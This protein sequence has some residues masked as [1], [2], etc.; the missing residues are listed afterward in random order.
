MIADI[1]G[2]N[3]HGWNSILLRTGVYQ[4]ADGEPAHIPTTISDDVE[5]G[6]RWALARSMGAK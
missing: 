5:A 1:A 2:A 4:D 6:V 3:G